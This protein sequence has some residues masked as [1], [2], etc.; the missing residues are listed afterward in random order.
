[1][2]RFLLKACSSTVEAY[3]LYSVLAES[4]V[5]HVTLLS[6]LKLHQKFKI[7]ALERIECH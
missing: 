3:F 6:F 5:S 2:V 7:L 1:M 4:L